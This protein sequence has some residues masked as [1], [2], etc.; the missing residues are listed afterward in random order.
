MGRLHRD[1]HDAGTITLLH[2][3]FAAF[4]KHRGP[5]GVGRIFITGVCSFVSFSAVKANGH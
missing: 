4:L 3:L 1:E 2:T 5:T